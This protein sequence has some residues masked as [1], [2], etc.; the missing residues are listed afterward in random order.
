MRFS[1]YLSFASAG[2]V[3]LIAGG[4]GLAQDGGEAGSAAS[5][6]FKDWDRNGDG[7]VE[8]GELPDR[9]RNQF[10][11]A[12][13]D[14]DGGISL[15]EHLAMVAARGGAGGIAKGKGQAMPKGGMLSD[16]VEA[17]LDIPYADTDNPR[18]RLDLFLPKDRS[19][20]G[21]LPMVVFVHGGG[22][23]AGDKGSG[24][25]QVARFVATGE[26]AG[27]SIGYRLTD[28]AQWPAQLHD[29]KAALRW[30]KGHAEQLGLDRNR[31]AVWGTSA[32]GHLVSILGTTSDVPELEGDLGKH[33]DQNGAV[34]C[35]INFF[36]PIDL[37]SMVG[38]KSTM[39]RTTEDYPEALLIG[40]RVQDHPE[41]A[42]A[43]S[44]IRYVS[45]GDPPVLTAHGTADPLVPF[46]QGVEFHEALKKAGVES[47]LVEMRGAGHG[48]RSAELDGRV[49]AFL[50]RHLRG[51]TVT[52]EEGAITLGDKDKGR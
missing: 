49:R 25:G 4:P 2:L 48:F 31:I 35:V 22:W 33:L 7:R 46:A 13:R 42:K 1:T 8:A 6:Q 37:V 45:A 32:G 14:G 5:K 28:E 24:A 43:A 11:R 36:G 39:N 51:E 44:P 38:Q 10:G 20:G 15:A 26:Y 17:R 47:L 50:A 29:C 18:Q 23:R 12:D 21:L 34:Q 27:A 52:I 41:K 9:L 40:G 16:A 3:L 19:K 30:I